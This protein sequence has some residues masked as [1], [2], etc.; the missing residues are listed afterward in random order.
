M[1]LLTNN[2][3]PG[4]KIILDFIQVFLAVRRYHNLGFSETELKWIDELQKKFVIKLRW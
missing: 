4:Q 3:M 2:S 1:V